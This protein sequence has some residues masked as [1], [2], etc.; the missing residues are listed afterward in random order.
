MKIDPT[1]ITRVSQ[2]QSVQELY[3]LIQAAIELE[4]ATIP[5]YLCGYFTL[6]LD[7]NE[8]V[9]Q[10]IL[11]VVIEE[12]LHMTH[13]CN[14]LNAIGGS[15]SIN[16]PKFVPNYPD[17]LPMG[18]GDN[19]QVHLRKCSVDQVSDIFMQIEEPEDPIDIPVTDSLVG[20]AASMPVFDTIGAFYTFLKK[21]LEELSQTQNIFTGDPARQVVALRW[22]PDPE[23]MFP[24]TDLASAKRAIDLIIDQGE[25]TSTDPFVSDEFDRG[26]DEPAHY[27]RFQEIVKGKKLIR[28]PGETPPY[29]FG[30]APVVLDMANV[31]DMDSDPKIDKYASSSRSRRM[32]EQFSYS[33]TRLLNA[34]H[35]TFNGAP[36][37]L[38]GAMGVMYELRLLAQQVLSTPAE[39]ANGTAPAG[40]MTGLSFEYQEVNT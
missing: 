17:G 12:M 30:G 40:T 11:S 10:I 39:Y 21:K 36:D 27:Y 9:A 22:F 3:P 35:N 19:L 32:A 20:F 16:D 24:V 23:E 38:D 5:P 26:D 8:E 4:H 33:Y 14:L 18:I 25:G 29:A 15:P 1:F 28:R 37:Q 31:W 13:A 7:T 2:A 6:Q 34:L